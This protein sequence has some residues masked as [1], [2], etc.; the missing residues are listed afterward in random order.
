MGLVGTAGKVLKVGGTKNPIG[1]LM[2]GVFYTGGLSGEGDNQVV[3]LSAL[4]TA[5]NAIQNGTNISDKEKENALK[6]NKEMIKELEDALEKSCNSNDKK[7]KKEE[8]RGKVHSQNG[9]E[10][11][12]SATTAD[13]NWN[14]SYAPPLSLCKGFAFRMRISMSNIKGHAGKGKGGDYEKGATKAYE[15]MIAWMDKTANGG[16]TGVEKW[17][18]NFDGIVYRGAKP[19]SQKKLK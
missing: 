5:E 15:T 12:V 16:G 17:S 3:Q 10:D 14:L 11:I 18:F 6:A 1:V 2:Q 7:C 4:N 19:P 9:K 8:H 13:T